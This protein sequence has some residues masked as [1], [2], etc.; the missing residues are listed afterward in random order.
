MALGSSSSEIGPFFSSSAPYPA[1]S[2]F[3][4]N[5]LSMKNNEKMSYC[6]A[7]E[8]HYTLFD[9]GLFSVLG[10]KSNEA[11]THVLIRGYCTLSRAEIFE[12]KVIFRCGCHRHNFS[13]PK[14]KSCSIF[15]NNRFSRSSAAIGPGNLPGK[16]TKKLLVLFPGRLPWP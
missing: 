10:R 13:Q 6:A 2:I 15:R 16:S 9:I 12:A 3:V 11:H 4:L 5:M 8:N 7:F 14:K 1:R